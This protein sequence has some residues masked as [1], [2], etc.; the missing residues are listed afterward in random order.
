VDQELDLEEA[1]AG[2]RTHPE[3]RLEGKVVGG[4]IATAAGQQS[5]PRR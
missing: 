1:H 5:I 4:K 3:K 2:R